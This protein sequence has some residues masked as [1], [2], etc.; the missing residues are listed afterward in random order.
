MEL[1]IDKLRKIEALAVSGVDGEKENARRLL[2]ALCKK[3]GITLD[4]L[5]NSERRLYKF[6]FSGKHEKTILIQ[7][8]G[9]VCDIHGSLTFKVLKKKRTEV[10]FPL[11]ESQAI[12]VY[13]CF[14]HYRKAWRKQQED[15]LTAF[16]H[17]NNLVAQ[18]ESPANDKS[19]SDNNT[20]RLMRIIQ[21]MQGMQSDQ[22]EKRFKLNA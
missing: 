2:D 15:F 9:Y 7:T 13:E 19:S 12:V 17:K 3:H 8:I 10:W 16:V 5:S 22:W 14:E 21:I 4:R 6:K 20:E 18:S 1:I 11:T